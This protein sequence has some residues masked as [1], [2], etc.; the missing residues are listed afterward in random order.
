MS[1]SIAQ[2]VPVRIK[3]LVTV[4][5]ALFALAVLAGLYAYYD[6]GHAPVEKVPGLRGQT[7]DQVTRV[8]GKPDLDESYQMR[9]AGGEFRIELRNTY[10]LDRPGNE[11]VEIRELW[12]KHSRF[13][14]AV[15]F[16]QIDGQWVALDSCRWKQG[17]QF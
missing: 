17:I 7:V 10:R 11:D 4:S 8:L 3:T 12:W 16:H 9:D 13:T 5:A 6:L 1:S 15:W 2:P 14:V